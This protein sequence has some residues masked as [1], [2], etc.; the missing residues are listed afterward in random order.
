M[1]HDIASDRL[2]GLVETVRVLPDGIGGSQL[3][4]IT[5]CRSTG[6]RLTFNAEDDAFCQYSTFPTA[7]QSGLRPSDSANE[8][9]AFRKDPHSVSYFSQTSL[10]AYDGAYIDIFSNNDSSEADSL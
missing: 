6:Y 9:Y 8:E 2:L 5:A 4:A 3:T 1:S 7:L 10:L